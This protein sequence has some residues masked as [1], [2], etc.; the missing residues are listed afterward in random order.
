VTCTNPHSSSEEHG[1]GPTIS[2]G[3]ADM[4]RFLSR[5]T[6]RAWSAAGN[7]GRLVMRGR[8]VNRRQR[9]VIVR[10]QETLYQ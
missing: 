2:L 4:A 1:A 8:D 6:V 10:E 7:D 3:E 5:S 9:N